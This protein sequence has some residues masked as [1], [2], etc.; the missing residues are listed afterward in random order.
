MTTIYIEEVTDDEND[1]RVKTN[2]ETCKALALSALVV[3]KWVCSKHAPCPFT[4]G[5]GSIL[6][7]INRR[8][9]TFGG[10]DRRGKP[11]S[12][13]LCYDSDTDEWQSD[14]RTEGLTPTARFGHSAVAYGS[15]IY[16][17]GGQGFSD[18]DQKLPLVCF[19]DL[20]CLDT[21]TMLWKELG[22]RDTDVPVEE[23]SENATKPSPRNS[24]TVALIGDDMI[25]FGGATEEGPMDDTWIFNLLSETWKK[26][27]GKGANGRPDAREMH[28][29]CVANSKL[30]IMGGRKDDGVVC[31]DLWECD[32]GF[33]FKW[34]RLA[35]SSSPRCSHGGGFLPLSQSLCFFGGWDGMGEVFGE[36]AVFNLS[37]MKWTATELREYIPA[38]R[39]GHA[40]CAIDNR[41]YILGGVNASDDLKDLISV[42]QEYLISHT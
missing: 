21:E 14:L 1:C 26:V 5:G 29:V 28:S 27:E 8:L 22:K 19:N 13:L 15:K 12:R 11:S 9:Y 30:Y 39:F 37:Q 25:V 17:F 4:I 16:I 34:T 31:K 7:N 41:L 32:P 33:G 40:T 36:L 20:H 42:Q 35:E 6:I 23:N 10:C 38:E 2:D 3:D 24:H 18:N